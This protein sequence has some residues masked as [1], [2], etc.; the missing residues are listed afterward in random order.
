[1]QRVV[2]HDFDV[3]AHF[4]A[5]GDGADGPPDV[6]QLVAHLL[7]RMARH[8]TDHGERPTAKGGFAG[9]QPQQVRLVPTLAEAN[10]HLG[11]TLVDLPL[12][13]GCI[14][15]GHQDGCAHASSQLPAGR[16]D[17]ERG[18]APTTV[19]AQ[20]QEPGPVG[21]RLEGG[22]FDGGHHDDLNRHVWVSGLRHRRRAQG[23]S[24]AVWNAFSS[25]RRRSA[26]PPAAPATRAT[27]NS[28]TVEFR[29]AA[30]LVAASTARWLSQ[31]PSQPTT[32]ASRFLGSLI[33][34][35]IAS[36]TPAAYGWPHPPSPLA[37]PGRRALGPAA[38]GIWR[39]LRTASGR[40]ALTTSREGAQAGSRYEQRRGGPMMVGVT[41]AP[42]AC[43]WPSGGSSACCCSCRW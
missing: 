40:S 11:A 26:R 15:P 10:M 8:R 27:D 42:A 28:R 22:R 23:D 29:R 14:V 39:A 19:P 34:L 35:T 37:R 18:L 16:S 30:S 3:A 25:K 7:P 13:T 9:G 4:L 41:W 43:G 6:L 20:D 38:P 12:L 17:G 21:H 1:M 24:P 33:C 31:E 2:L 32:T 36:S 5:L